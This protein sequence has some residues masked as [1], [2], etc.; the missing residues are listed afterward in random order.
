MARKSRRS[1]IISIFLI[2]LLIYVAIQWI[3]PSLVNGVGFIKHAVKPPKI[4]VQQEAVTVAPP[5]LNIPFEAT[6]TAQINIH[7]YGAPSSK[8]EIFLDDDKKDIVDVG[9]DGTF[10]F[11]NIQLSLGTNN[12]YGKSLDEKDQESLPSKTFIVIYDNEDPKLN[13]SEPEDNKKIQ[14]GDKK[15]T[16]SGNTELGAK[17]FINGS[18]III[19]KDGNFKSEQMINEGD[20]NF[21][22]SAIDTAENKTEI[23]RKVTYTP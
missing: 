21:T 9:E 20:N 3:L 1:F 10:E 7:G 6:R 12:I 22:I 5:V 8:V 16:I 19:D 18:Q 15:V 13:I 11:K 4:L 17:I 23:Q 14:G 2:G